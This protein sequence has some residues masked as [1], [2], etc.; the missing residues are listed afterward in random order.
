[1]KGLRSLACVPPVR[2]PRGHLSILEHTHILWNHES[3]L[4]AL[5]IKSRILLTVW[6]ALEGLAPAN[7]YGS[8]HWCHA[9]P[10]LAFP[11]ATRN[12]SLIPSANESLPLHL[13]FHLSGLS[14]AAPP[15]LGTRAVWGAYPRHS[16]SSWGL[17]HHWLVTVS[18]FLKK[19]KNR[20]IFISVQSQGFWKAGTVFHAVLIPRHP[21]WGLAPTQLLKGGSREI[22]G[23]TTFPIVDR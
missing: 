3:F 7:L 15:T 17:E 21:A 12:Q 20:L 9:A 18:L 14:T 4:I 16:L 5:E 13:C 10:T 22:I 6:R 11:P 23:K 1:M 8:H 19:K 2:T